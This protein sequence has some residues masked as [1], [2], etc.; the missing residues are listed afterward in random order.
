MRRRVTR[1]TEREHPASALLDT[2]TT[3]QVLGIINREDRKVAPAVGRVIPQI[4]RAVDL[5][6]AALAEGGRL[7]YLGAGTSGRLGMLDAAECLPTFG[8]DRIVA[9]MAGAPAA[10]AQ[11][12]EGVEDDPRQAARDLRRIK[13]N[14]KD[15]LVGI[16]ASGR[17]PYTLGGLRYA[18]RVGAKTVAITSNPRAPMRRLAD[19]AIV[20]VVGPEVVAGSTRLKSGTAQKLVLNM[21]STVTMVRLGRV[22]SHWMIH[23]QMINEKL[24]K[25]G[26]EI[27]VSVTGASPAGA[28]RALEESGR[29]L[30]AAV[31]MLRKGLSK[32]EALRLLRKDENTARALR[33]AWA[34]PA[35]AGH[36]SPRHERGSEAAPRRIL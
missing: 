30:P 26:R 7:V 15:V 17:T 28:A 31:L 25:R 34:G 21:L 6:V 29:N 20:P 32:E 2:K 4:A 5:A 3:Q 27:L 8:T 16:A 24:Q 1:I 18:R 13:F 22:F 10:L 35:A 33:A 12:K 11:P 9:V 19:V 14:R 23:V 36:N